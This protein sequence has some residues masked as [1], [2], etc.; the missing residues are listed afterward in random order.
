MENGKSN[1]N[2]KS[3]KLAGYIEP[4][5]TRDRYCALSIISNRRLKR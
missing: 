2:E 5:I 4:S 3:V 1:T